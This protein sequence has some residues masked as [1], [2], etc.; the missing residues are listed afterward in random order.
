MSKHERKYWNFQEEKW[1]F[2]ET[3]SLAESREQESRRQFDECQEHRDTKE[4]KHKKDWIFPYYDYESKVIKYAPTSK[5]AA[6]RR[7]ECIAWWDQN[8][9][10][11]KAEHLINDSKAWQQ[12]RDQKVKSRIDN[13]NCN[14]DRMFH[15][16]NLGINIRDSYSL[17]CIKKAFRHQALLQHPDHDKTMGSA[18]RFIKLQSSYEYLCT[19]ANLP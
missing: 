10:K 15:C 6:K 1:C 5:E 3:L 8:E 14:K 12:C 16:S 17:Q 13:N 18:E 7:L 2:A 19:G 4:A 9:A 11:K